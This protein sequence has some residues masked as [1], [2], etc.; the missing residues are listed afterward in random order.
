[1]EINEELTARA[2]KIRILI[3]DVDGVLTPGQIILDNEGNEMKA[4]HVRDGHGIKMLQRAGIPVGIITGRKSKVVELRAKELG[5][6]PHLVH[7]GAL[8]KLIAF[9]GFVKEHGYADDEVA[10]IG[11]DIVDIPVMSRVGLAFAVGDA[12]EYVKESAHL[13]SARDGGK[14]AVREIID[15]LLKAKGKWAAVTAKYFC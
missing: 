1:M 10:Y 7:Q 2:R 5:I 15:Y 9:Q 3:T 8:D 11:D 12:E 13:V 6:E 14:A 4:F